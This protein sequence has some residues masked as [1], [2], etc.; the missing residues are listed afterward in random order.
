MTGSRGPTRPDRTI[1]D[2]GE[3]AESRP[4]PQFLALHTV[5]S[6]AWPGRLP[7]GGAV[8]RRFS[9]QIQKPLGWTP[10]LGQQGTTRQ[11]RPGFLQVLA[12]P[13]GQRVC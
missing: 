10:R 11:H 2:R 4:T 9:I 7:S 13:A 8:G 1:S 3:F 12:R 5:L 6:A